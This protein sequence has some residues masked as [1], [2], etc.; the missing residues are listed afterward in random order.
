M[1]RN[2]AF[3]IFGDNSFFTR[4]FAWAASIHPRSEVIHQI[5][6]KCGSVKH[7]P[8]G[9]FDVTLE[10]G[11]KYPDILGCGA[12]PFLIASEKVIEAWQEVG[13]GFFHTYK[14]NVAEN[15]SAKLRNL[16]APRY[17]RVEIDGRCQ[18]DLEAS[19][20]KVIQFCPECDHLVTDPAVLPGF[21]IVSGSWD[22]NVLFRDPVYFPRIN[23][24]TDIALKIAYRHQLTNFR[25][26]PMTG[27]L[28][29]GN[30]GINYLAGHT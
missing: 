30:K 23:F 8:S 25:F 6:P 5:C 4:G 26:E 20:A 29:S 16:A 12:Y 2:P 1:S 18:I 14:V 28:D 15:K 17:Y 9:D 19:G 11:S 27:P 7:Y 13:L 10:K 24:C 21:H 22:G 3:Y